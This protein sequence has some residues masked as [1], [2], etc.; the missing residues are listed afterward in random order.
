MRTVFFFF[1]LLDTGLSTEALRSK[2]TCIASLMKTVSGMKPKVQG[3]GVVSVVW[4][5]VIHGPVSVQHGFIYCT[6]QY[7]TALK[8]CNH[9]RF[10][11]HSV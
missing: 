2:V 3:S 1:H 4:L 7:C 10:C 9:S 5:N 8:F 6:V 11:Y